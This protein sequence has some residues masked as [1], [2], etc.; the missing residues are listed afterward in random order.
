MDTTPL[1]FDAN[2]S[3]TVDVTGKKSIDVINSGNEK[4]RFTVGVTIAAVT[5]FQFM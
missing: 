1:Y 4:M 2:V 3:K 5:C